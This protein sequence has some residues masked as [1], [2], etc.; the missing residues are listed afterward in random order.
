MDVAVQQVIQSLRRKHIPPEMIVGTD[1]K[2]ALMLLRMM[3]YNV[4]DFIARYTYPLLP[5]IMN[6][7]KKETTAE[8]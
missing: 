2:Y 8:K 4:I 7:T 6:V 5:A 3:P 1:A